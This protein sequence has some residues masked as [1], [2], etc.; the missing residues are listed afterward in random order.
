MSDIDIIVARTDHAEANAVL[1]EQ[2]AE[3]I[4]HSN[5]ETTWRYGRSARL[6]RT[7]TYLHRDDPWAI[8]LHSTLDRIPTAGGS[9]V[10]FD[11]I[12]A[13]MIAAP[14]LP[15]PLLTLHL[16]TH[17]GTE[18]HSL[19]LIRLVELALVIRQDLTSGSL[20]WANLLHDGGRAGAL[21]AIYPALQLCERLCPGTVPAGVL[22]RCEAAAPAAVV[23]IVRDMT[24]ADAQRL[25]RHSFSEHFMWIRGPSGIVRQVFNDLLLRDV[26]RGQ[27]LEMA[28]LRVRRLRMGLMTR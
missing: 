27:F 14:G 19:T 13:G 16:A 5:I 12:A 4:W 17:A 11:K 20:D 25:Q 3:A 15:Q 7:L 10:R 6:P 23:R 21:G 22:A 24:P 8:D 1:R 28:R 9:W 2:G 18:F 26:A